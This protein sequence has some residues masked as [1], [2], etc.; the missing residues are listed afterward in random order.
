MDWVGAWWIEAWLCVWAGGGVLMAGSY[1]FGCKWCAS[2]SC[3]GPQ[4]R[5]AFACQDLGTNAI[6]AIVQ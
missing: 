5:C 3:N 6:S 4:I 2:R 1:V